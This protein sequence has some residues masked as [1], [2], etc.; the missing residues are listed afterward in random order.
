MSDPAPRLAAAYLPEH[1]LLGKGSWLSKA[2]SPD[3]PATNQGSNQGRLEHLIDHD[4]I[5]ELRDHN[6]HHSAALEAKIHSTVGLGHKSTDVA[7]QLNDLCHVSWQDTLDAVVSDYFEYGNGY[8]EVVRGDGD[9][10]VALF[11]IP[12]RDI[13]ICQETSSADFHYELREKGGF[14]AS[15]QITGLRFARFGDREDF[16]RR[17]EIPAERQPQVSEVIHFPRNRGRRSRHYGYPEWLS[18][19]PAMELDHCVVQYAFDF[20]FH[21]GVPEGIY[22]VLGKTVDKDD[23]E[24]LQARFRDHTGIGNRRKIMLLNWGD[25]DITAQFDKLTLDGQTIGDQ[26][27]LIDSNALKVVTAHRVPPLLAG[28]QIPGKLG[29]ANEMSNAMMAFQTLAVGPSQKQIAQVLACTLGND[30]LNGGIS[31]DESDFLGSEEDKGNGFHTILDEIDLGMM[32]TIG[33]AR[34]SVS[35]MDA[36]GRDVSAGVAERGG[37]VEAGRGARR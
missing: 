34:M 4:A 10:I 12:A 28:I 16:I 17:Q 27:P 19:V 9:E 20:F 18:A 11:H 6:A 36:R 2:A 37:D 3:L 33:R 30:V 14:V 32:D 24:T 5:R 25:P 8:L 15:A 31:L 23:W 1:D 22:T 35:E 7:E 21:G 26:Q 29:A 13:W